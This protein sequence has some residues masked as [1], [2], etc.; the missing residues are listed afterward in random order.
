MRLLYPLTHL[1]FI[2]LMPLTAFGQGD[3]VG[4]IPRRN[5]LKLGLTSTFARTVS[6]N[7]ERALNADWSV[8]LTVSYMMPSVP[9]GLLDLNAER[10]T[11]G[12]DRRL[13]GYYL[14]PEVKWFVEKSDKRPAPR[15]LYVGA[16]L[17]YS[18]TRYTATMTATAIGDNADGNIVADLRIDLLEFGIGP[19]VGYQFLCLGDRLAIDAVFFAPRWS[20]YTLKVK[21][22]L[23]GE[24]ELYSDLAQAIEEKLGRNVTNMSID[25]S[26]SG[27]TTVDRNSLGYRYG[28]KIGYA[29]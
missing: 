21:A 3:S 17:R 22:D 2:F 26:T 27:T 18:D 19:G 5:V 6:L 20:L 9:S 11:F 28:I 8:A 25:L 29:F 12:A 16:Y 15:G 24:G 23:Q 14:T 1:L 4:F 10:I 7:Y 13:S